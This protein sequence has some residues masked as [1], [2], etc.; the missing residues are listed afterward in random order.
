MSKER[1]PENKT[2][3]KTG[4]N[5]KTTLCKTNQISLKHSTEPMSAIKYFAT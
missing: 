4:E 3:T 5:L 2:K 1:L